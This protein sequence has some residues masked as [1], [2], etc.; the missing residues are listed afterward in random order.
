MQSIGGMLELRRRVCYSA[1]KEYLSRTGFKVYP[2]E[3]D[4]GSSKHPL[5]DIAARTGSFFWA[6]EYKSESDSVSRGLEQVECYSRWFDYV[7]L[8]SERCFNQARSRCF[9]ELRAGGVGIWTY[10][11]SKNECIERKNPR[12]QMPEKERRNLVARR[13]RALDR[14]SSK[15]GVQANLD[16]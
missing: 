15:S 11:P 5:V 9:W 14:Y 3:F 4:C 1:F 10:L 12:L 2:R 7:V 13:F 8:V 16:F 6:F